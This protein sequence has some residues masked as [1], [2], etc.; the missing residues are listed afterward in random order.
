MAEEAGEDSAGVGLAHP[1]ADL[2]RRRQ[3]E[4]AEQPRRHLLLLHPV[5]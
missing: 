5:H 2:L 3:S 1:A 4:V